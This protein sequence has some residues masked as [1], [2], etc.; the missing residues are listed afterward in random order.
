M[1]Q[2]YLLS[3][4]ANAVAGLTL[5]GEFIGERIPFLSLFKDLREN[6]R[7]VKGIGAAAVIIGIIKLFVLSPGETVIIAGDLLPA[8]TGM[9][10]GAAL[11][12][13]AFRREKLS[14]A[15]LSFRVPLGITGVLV[16]LLHFL[17]PGA[18]LL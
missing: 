3:I 11:L 13:E 18:P 10:I 7:A 15:I 8:F 6:E 12:I 5:A 17:V 16:A 9:V 2:F 1:A 14:A 4:L